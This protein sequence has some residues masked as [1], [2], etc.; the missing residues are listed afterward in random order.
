MRLGNNFASV[1]GLNISKKDRSCSPATL[2]DVF[3]A[4][5]QFVQGKVVNI[6]S[7]RDVSY[8]YFKLDAQSHYLLDLNAE[9]AD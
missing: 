2:I 1:D 8:K 9:V 3:T 6:A 4:K 7:D 5:Y